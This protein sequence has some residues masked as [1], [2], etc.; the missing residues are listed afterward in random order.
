MPIQSIQTSVS[1]A[2]PIINSNYLRIKFH[3]TTGAAF[4]YE[5][6]VD[7]TLS[8]G[9]VS[10]TGTTT[11]IWDNPGYM[12]PADGAGN[13]TIVTGN[14]WNDVL[15]GRLYPSGSLVMLC[16]FRAATNPGA[17]NRGIFQFG[18]HNATP[19]GFRVYTSGTNQNIQVTVQPGSQSAKTVSLNMVSHLDTEVTFMVAFDGAND[20]V[21]VGLNGDWA[22]SDD[23]AMGGEMPG[24]WT[25][26]WGTTI[27]SYASSGPTV[28]TPMIV[29]G[30]QCLRTRF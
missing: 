29:T 28:S 24:A 20:L 25:S 15:D 30:K 26:T 9:S 12:T 2:D 10:I 1:S 22:G 3:E 7:G 17:V 18:S 21:S 13:G 4:A 23:D 8:T 14:P 27:F 5:K 11:N 19:G 16:R 6:K